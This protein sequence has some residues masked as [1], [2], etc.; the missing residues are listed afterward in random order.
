[1]KLKLLNDMM[2][3]IKVVDHSSF[4]GAAT[5]LG[6][7]K[8]AISKYITRLEKNLGAQLLHRSTRKLILT[9]AGRVLYDSFAKICDD[10][11]EAER[12]VS[13]TNTVPRG[14][15][16]IGAPLSFGT[17]HMVSAVK[18]FIALYPEMKIEISHGLVHDD[19]LSSGM[20]L[21]IHIGELPNS[22][23]LVARRLA[24][25]GL[26]VCAA[27]S[28]V[29]KYGR[30]MIPEDLVDHNCLTTE[31]ST[32]GTQWHFIRDKQPFS[33]S[34]K[35]NFTSRGTPILEAAAVAGLGVVMLPG[36][37]MTQDVNEGRLTEFL[38]EYCP[39]NIGI[40]A[41]Y[42]YTRHVSPKVR[43]FIDF[44]VERYSYEQYWRNNPSLQ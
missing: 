37:M 29:E 1:M 18:D 14:T 21:M 16:R 35:G 13:Y 25:R 34:V 24:V 42:P 8:S 43:A 38:Y 20:D 17:L 7:S 12:V 6:I 41:V 2:I 39:K 26:R 4:T 5:D 31:A 36:Y 28:Y 27:P 9:E 33:V 44:L 3:F 19:F 32:S 30:P 10:L 40:Y 11:E 22:P 23:N 15:L